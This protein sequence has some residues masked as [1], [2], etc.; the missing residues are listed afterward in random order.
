MHRVYDGDSTVPDLIAANSL[1]D[2]ANPA[3][4]FAHYQ[5][6]LVGLGTT[7]S[8][9]MP[10]L[11]LDPI[12]NT[13][14]TAVSA[15]L[16]PDPNPASVAPTPFTPTQLLGANGNYLNPAFVLAGERTG[17]DV[18]ANNILAFDVK[19]YDPGAPVIAAAGVDGGLGLSLGGAPPTFTG[20]GGQEGS[21]DLIL[22]PNDP[23]YAAAYAGT[24]KVIS[25]GE[26]VDLM[27]GRKTLN[28]LSSYS[29]TYASI[30]GVT[31]APNLFT[32]LSGLEST[33]AFTDGLTRSGK[34]L[35]L[36]S[37]VIVLQPTYDTW[38]TAYDTTEPF[39]RCT[40]RTRRLP[41]MAQSTSMLLSARMVGDQPFRLRSSIK[42]QTAWI[43][44]ALVVL[45]RWRNARRY[46]LSHQAAGSKGFR[47]DRRLEGSPSQANV[48]SY[49]IRNAV[50]CCAADVLAGSP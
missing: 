50:G 15:G 23:G 43:T 47:A 1:E 21:D 40:L 42:A 24:H 29:M 5:Y 37:G 8:C 27:W 14:L 3:N 22:T 49:R 2:L 9:T 38:T 39:R 6:S 32:A 28:S 46:R 48:G 18:I 35:T 41:P 16:Y 10:L 33:L 26:Y 12:S 36:P 34:A 25:H 20:V 7:G 30:S 11:V 13:E 17:E 19:G 4:R 31:P 44:I 45:M